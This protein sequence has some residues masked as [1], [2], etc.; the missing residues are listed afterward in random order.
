MKIGARITMPFQS[1]RG[2]PLALDHPPGLSFSPNPSLSPPPPPHPR[3]KNTKKPPVRSPHGDHVFH[4]QISDAWSMRNWKP[5]DESGHDHFFATFD[6]FI[7]AS[8]SHVAEGVASVI[9]RAAK[10][11][12][13]Y[14][15]F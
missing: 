6:K 8:S 9:D 10:E 4:N 11:H 3:Q 13:Q 14:I 7:P 5:G 12:V 1:F 2:P 15:E